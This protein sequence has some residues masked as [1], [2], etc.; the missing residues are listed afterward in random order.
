MTWL[1]QT[2]SPSKNLRRRR[3]LPSDSAHNIDRVS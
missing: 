1:G 3:E 2:V